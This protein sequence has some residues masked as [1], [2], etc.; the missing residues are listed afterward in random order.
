MPFRITDGLCSLQA[1]GCVVQSVSSRFVVIKFPDLSTPKRRNELS[2]IVFAAALDT[3]QL[4]AFL[5]VS[6]SLCRH[7]RSRLPQLTQTNLNCRSLGTRCTSH[8]LNAYMICR[9]R[10]GS[11]YAT[12]RLLAA[13]LLFSALFRTLLLCPR[14]YLHTVVTA[15]VRCVAYLSPFLASFRKVVRCLPVR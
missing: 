15:N 8:A 1:V 11:P 6:K 12:L 3:Q 14:I 13:Y 10:C 4:R 7:M 9:R 5:F 2:T